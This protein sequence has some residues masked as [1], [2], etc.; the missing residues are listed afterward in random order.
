MKE[1]FREEGVS[2]VVGTILILA[3]TVALFATVFAYVQH[4]PSPSKTP[5]VI[6]FPSIAVSNN[7]LY[8]NLTDKGGSTFLSNDTFLIVNSNGNTHSFLLYDL[9]KKST[10]GP[11][12]TA[13]LNGS[14]N[15]LEVNSGSSL[16][17]ILFSK[18]YNS[19][20]WKSQNFIGNNLLIVNVQVTPSPI[21]PGQSFTVLA[22]LYTLSPSS[23]HVY[24]NL[25]PSFN[26]PPSPVNISMI[27]IPSSGN[28]VE[29]YVTFSAP[30]LLPTNPYANVTAYSQGQ[31]SFENI[32]LLS[33]SAYAPLL[34]ISRDGI[35]PEYVRPEHGSTDPISIIV[36]NNGPV[37][38]TFNMFIYDEFPNGSKAPITNNYGNVKLGNEYII[39]QNF[40]IG[41]LS[42]TTIN[43]VWLNVGGNNSTAGGNYLIVGIT[44]IV[45]L[46]NLR[47]TPLPANSSYYIYIMPKILL[48]NDQ[49][50]ASGTQ[51]D[52]GNYYSSLLQ[53]TAYQFK[54]VSVGSNQNVSL[55]GYDVVIW[56]TGNNS[57]GLSPIQQNDLEY[58]YN[59]GGK[60]FLISG[61]ST[62]YDNS[63]KQVKISKSVVVNISGT[64]RSAMNITQ[65]NNAT[66]GNYSFMDQY[67]VENPLFIWMVNPTAFMTVNNNTPITVAEYSIN[68]NG[69]KIVTVGFEFARL[70]LYQQDYI[71]NKILMWLAD[72]KTL[73]GNQ[74]VLSDIQ[75]STKAPLFYQNVTVSFVITNLSPVNLTTT[76][77]MLVNNNFYKYING[78]NVPYDGGFTI[79]NVTWPAAPPGY[80]LITGIVD[81]FHQISQIN[82]A[83]DVES[84]VVNSTVNV[85]FSTLV[86]YDGSSSQKGTPALNSTLASIDV[87]FNWVN[88]N[89]ESE[90]SAM[91][92][93]TTFFSHYNLI[94]ID[95]SGSQPSLNQSL[96]NAII[97]YQ[98]LKYSNPS[99]PYSIIFVGNGTHNLLTESVSG[100]SS[101][102]ASNFYLSFNNYK[103]K[104][105]G[106]GSNALFYLYGINNTS[107]GDFGFFGNN[108]TNSYGLVVN[109]TPGNSLPLYNVTDSL[110]SE[111]ILSS[112][113]NFISST[114]GGPGIIVNDTGF[115]IVVIPFS[116]SSIY[117]IIQQH[118]EAF[119]PLSP[120]ADARAWFMLNIMGYT[121][122]TTNF[123]VPEV[124][125]SSISFSSPVLMINRYYLVDA[126]ISNLGNKA[127]TAVVQAYDGS[128]MFSSETVALPALSTVPVQFI[129]DPQYAA[130]PSNPRDIRIVISYS[131]SSMN[132]IFNFV[133][134]GIR[135]TPVY[136]FYDNL[137]TGNNW[138]SYATVWAWSGVNEYANGTDNYYS[139][140]P[141]STEGVAANAVNGTY[142]RVLKK[143]GTSLE[144]YPAPNGDL[145]PESSSDLFQYIGIHWGLF[146]DS[147]SGGYS[148]GTSSSYVDYQYYIGNLNSGWNSTYVSKLITTNL[149]IHG[150]KYMYLEFYALY[151]LA[152]GGEGV[153]VFISPNG[154]GNGKWIWIS[155]EQGYPGN[156]YDGELTSQ[157]TFPQNS[158][159]LL[160][161]FTTVSGG[162][163]FGWQHYI[164]NLSQFISASDSSISIMFVLIVDNQGYYTGIYGN[165]FFYADDIK[166]IENS[167]TLGEGQNGGD[168]WNREYSNG[169]W[170][171]NSSNLYQ[172]EVDNV[173]SVPIS[174]V[175][176][177]NATLS[178]LAQYSIY[179]RYA[180]AQDPTDVPNGFRLYIGYLASGGNIVWNQIDTRW[181]GEAGL[182][183]WEN[184]SLI[185][186]AFYSNVYAFHQ[187][188]NFISLTGYIGLTVY[189]KF[190]V[191]GDSSTYF[192]NQYYNSYYSATENNVNEPTS[193]NF[194]ADFTDVVITG[195]SY[196]DLIIVNSIWT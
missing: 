13:Y 87:P 150:S 168:L 77:E 1:V 37:G 139:V 46:N 186:S 63:I 104:N 33:G 164:F 149:P 26:S 116:I 35:V 170:F 185:P 54:E 178:F 73:S 189:I 79:V 57:N 121:G 130:L 48:V 29:Y 16:S 27:P 140:E 162:E 62:S 173:V 171:Y 195:T 43:V 145:I 45:G 179:A 175:N 7:I 138:H 82:Y 34:S 58:F 60:I 191:N 80:D 23:T 132:P 81:P 64:A 153:A 151:K 95:S 3:I 14:E 183:P 6:I 93:I 167:S 194:W 187:T 71:A 156:V 133:R 20:V 113:W 11:G 84:S 161:A 177:D 31:S 112:N 67:F 76:L 74:L 123:A 70:Y 17:F 106:Q 91:G 147:I 157:W 190:E 65:L 115:K 108:I 109:A 105:I 158:A 103:G 56:F 146:P 86:L 111:Q 96:Y 119:S 94:I 50:A 25:N 99:Y 172:E 131:T 165:D 15:N 66:A 169:M 4:V 110:Q 142:L 30:L 98:K 127:T 135:T 39:N 28:F 52:V 89:S 53:Y 100:I 59:Q 85:R 124:V 184:A 148:I 36:Q 107:S 196:A 90:V 51:Q 32:S 68:N 144:F 143:P 24:L 9:T 160:P 180:N 72:I 83:L 5:S 137:S 182:I 18:Q 159:D 114:T 12:D 174:F 118:S 154:Q 163:N 192:D 92:N 193:S 188:G 97:S 141:Y 40:T 41:A 38:A 101:T 136:V 176:L 22:Y 125:S 152:L 166:V 126:N 69:G 47:Q 181:A 78:I 120:T 117:G 19:I 42:S 10:F 61:Y 49:G 122:Y 44:N 75:F 102:L 129:W 55:Q 88:F 134:E 155:P 2:E 8:L 21:I 128:G